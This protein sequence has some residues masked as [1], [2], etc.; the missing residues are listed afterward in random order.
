MFRFLAGV[1]IGF[2]M[3]VAFYNAVKSHPAA[4]AIKTGKE[5]AAVVPASAKFYDRYICK[6]T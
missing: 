2:V 3:A 4:P 5:C 6:L 1:V